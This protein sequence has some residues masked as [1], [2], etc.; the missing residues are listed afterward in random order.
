[1]NEGNEINF[2]KLNKKKWAHDG[3]KAPPYPCPSL[4]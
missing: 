2:Q 1:M 4:P 3:V